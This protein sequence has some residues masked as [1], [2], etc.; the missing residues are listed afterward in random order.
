LNFLRSRWF[1]LAAFALA[2]SLPACSGSAGTIPQPGPTVTP[3][4]NVIK[5][6]VA[7]VT[8]TGDSPESVQISQPGYDGTFTER[9]DCAGLARVSLHRNGNG[10]AELVIIPIGKGTCSITITG[11]GGAK[12]KLPLTVAPSPVV[13]TP[14]SLS[15]S[16][17]GASASQDVSVSQSDF[18][19]GFKL[20]D[21]CSGIAR[22][23]ATA[24]AKGAATYKVTPLAKGSC[25]ATF[26][27]GLQES[28]SVF[29]DVEPPGTVN[30]K[31]E[32]LAFTSTGSGAT[33]RAD[34]SQ[35]GYVGKFTESDDCATIAQLRQTANANGNA[36]YDVTPLA[37]GDCV[38]TFAGGNG[39]VGRLSISVAPPGSVL[40]DPSSLQFET[41]GSAATQKVSVSQQ[42]FTGA[43]KETD[44]C[45]GIAT[46]AS[47]VNANGH[48]TY[49]VTPVA[50]GACAATFEG[51][52]KETA[53]L[54]ITVAP[55]G[56]IVVKP[57]SLS[58][59]SVGS[60]AAKPVAVSQSGFTGS[61]GES[62]NCNG[63]ATVVASSNAGG[64]ASYVVT[65]VASGTCAATF[66]GGNKETSPLPVS[67]MA[68][69]PG[70][71]VVTPDSLT[72][73]ALGPSAAQN[74]TVS[75]SHYDGAFTETNTCA[76]I[77]TIAASTTTGG[78]TAA[79]SVTAVAQG[80]CSATF[81]GGAGKSAPLT[82]SV[83]QTQP[84]N[85]IVTPNSLKF[86][87]L[88]PS[89]S[90]SVTVSQTHYDG[91]FTE[92]DTCTGIATVSAKTGGAPGAY[93]VTA[94]AQGTCSATFTGGGGKSAPLS[95]TVAPPVTGDVVVSPSSLTFTSLGPDGAQNVTVS[96]AH[97]EG[98]FSEKDTCAGIAVVAATKA[99]G[100]GSAAYAVTALAK[101]TCSATF[102]GGGGKSTPLPVAVAPL[103]P[104][105]V[106]PSSLTFVATGPGAARDVAISQSGYTG[107]FTESNTCAGI[108]TLTQKSDTGGNA[109]YSVTPVANGDCIAT[110]TGGNREL[111]PLEVSVNVPPPGNVV[112]DPS[113]L[114]FTSTGAGAAKNVKVSQ[115]G[116]TGSFT[117]TNTCT[118]IATI[119]PANASGKTEFKVTPLAKGDCTATFHGGNGET[120][121][122]SIDVAPPGTVELDPSSLQ[123]YRSGSANAKNVNVSQTNYAGVF[124]ETNTCSGIATVT[125]TINA[126]GKATYQVVADAKG[127][128]TVT[129]TGSP[130][131]SAPLPVT[132][133]LP[134]AVVVKPSS[135][136]FHSIGFT[137]YVEVS[138][139]GYL[140]SFTVS[141]ACTQAT[142]AR[143][144]GAFGHE[145]F[146]VTA[147]KLGTCEAT[148]E[149]AN[150]QKT[151]LPITVSG[152]PTGPVLTAPGS[153]KF[154]GTGF[155]NAQHL[156]IGQLFYEGT[157]RISGCAGI[158]RFTEIFN[159]F[160]V[161]DFRVV[162]ERRGKC[163]ATITGGEGK[164]ANVPIEVR[165]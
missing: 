101:G 44:T 34:V 128:C 68:P 116:F 56:S 102:T 156:L 90:Q 104:V 106:T 125:A 130:G 132:V 126:A 2:L 157:F 33:R 103:G 35:N 93:S 143:I 105:E 9:D 161:A 158:A 112:V 11:G 148:F 122:L 60:S 76:G 121:P 118:G 3:P 135:L 152:F 5:L 120:A 164:T 50:K 136:A 73:T 53:P 150:A 92:K 59:E 15:F 97:Y 20:A 114:T 46:I 12:V 63:I 113:A 95:I 77:A 72:F 49:R 62:D 69:S 45:S 82:I 133:T 71:V 145:L 124:S 41:T 110:F 7:S 1:G 115:S 75:Q 144:A 84:G 48:A 16:A 127:S 37:K 100:T 19:K 67:V 83:M 94:I 149:G 119:V 134:G 147:T 139:S 162:P 22:I 42:G 52:R 107:A 6:S 8:I 151:S 55:P 21:N 80:T 25:T 23:A 99:T 18:S 39:A 91:A 26:D 129:F 81:T 24:N 43:F 163:S 47:S 96:Q 29:I 155:G 17:T 140:G 61:F 141:T 14:A 159:G 153:L 64:R 70:D 40:V 27:G 109:S 31:P 98:S 111:A 4:P 10:E 85:V 13:A 36:S 123:F 86:T 146:A 78:G 117:E 54:S 51:G 137:K 88:G 138:Q 142:I 57:A 87:V 131:E 160:G 108:A 74:V 28:A 66:S 38:A 89:G 154:D 79:Y 165:R 58:F 65:P 32:S 30:V